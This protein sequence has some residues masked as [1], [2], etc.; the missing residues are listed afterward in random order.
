MM[1]RGGFF[2][3]GLLRTH[4]S[5]L[6]ESHSTW[7]LVLADTGR[8]GIRYTPMEHSKDDDR[9]EEVYDLPPSGAPW[10]LCSC[11]RTLI[12]DTPEQNA[13]YG[14]EPYP[15]DEGFGEC[16]RCYGDPAAKEF[17]DQLGWAGRTFYD[18]RIEI[19]RGLLSP[20]KRKAFDELSYER[21]VIFIG[22]AIERGL[23]I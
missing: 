3:V 11:C 12:A 8:D 9:G 2:F 17:R 1:Y 23:L 7:L 19:V 10:L 20:Q 15:H 16:L 5:F 18:V 6:I 21:K 13:C 4:P 22:R 14:I